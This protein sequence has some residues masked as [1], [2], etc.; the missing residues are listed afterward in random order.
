MIGWV[1]GWFGGGRRG[2]CFGRDFGLWFGVDDGDCDRDSDGKL[3]GDGDGRRRHHL[4]GGVFRGDADWTMG[5]CLLEL[6]SLKNMAAATTSAM[7]IKLKNIHFWKFN[8]NSRSFYTF[9]S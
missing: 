4:R 6:G 9:I 5:V 1:F 8:L 7:K 3:F 2:Y